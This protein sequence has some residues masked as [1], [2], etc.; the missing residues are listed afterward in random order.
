MT[1]IPKKRT[2][3]DKGNFVKNTPK[4]TRDPTF[5]SKQMSNYARMPYILRNRNTY[6]SPQ[7]FQRILRG[8]NR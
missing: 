7:A 5:A 4:T 2:R 3:L 8:D 6:K 1:T